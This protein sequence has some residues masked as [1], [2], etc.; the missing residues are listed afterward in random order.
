MPRHNVFDAERLQPPS[1]ITV[2]Q[3]PLNAMKFTW[4]PAR[5]VTTRDGMMYGLWGSHWN[6]ISPEFFRR[7]NERGHRNH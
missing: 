4:M 7:F 2:N 6:V 1:G 5:I 3:D